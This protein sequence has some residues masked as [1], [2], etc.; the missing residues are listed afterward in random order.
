VV[1]IL[2]RIGGV[3]LTWC[4]DCGGLFVPRF[5]LNDVRISVGI[6]EKQGIKDNVDSP[7]WPVKL[8]SVS[9]SAEWG[10]HLQYFSFLFWVRYLFSFAWICS[11]EWKHVSLRTGT[12]NNTLKSLGIFLFVQSSPF[13]KKKKKGLEDKVIFYSLTYSRSGS[14]L[15]TVTSSH[16]FTAM[17]VHLCQQD[18]L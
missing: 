11:C 4:L 6:I 5:G 18:Q 14:D 7:V 2:R 13:K 12:E 16:L 9:R 3:F 17:A 8:F 1:L 10:R 15:L